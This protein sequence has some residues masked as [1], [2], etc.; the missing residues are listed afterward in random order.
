MYSALD[1][2]QNVVF[3]SGFNRKCVLWLIHAWFIMS[4]QPTALLMFIQILHHVYFLFNTKYFWNLF[5]TTKVLLLRVSHWHKC[6]TCS[7]KW[8]AASVSCVAETLDEYKSTVRV[9]ACV[10]TKIRSLHMAWFCFCWLQL[11]AYLG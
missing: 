1:N 5:F 3:S 4:F 2:I 8:L 9:S 10:Q 11:Q 7:V 6:R